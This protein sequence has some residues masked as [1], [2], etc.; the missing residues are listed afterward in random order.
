MVGF[1]VVFL[2]RNRRT[3]R[4][5]IPRELELVLEATPDTL[6][7]AV[8]F[9]GTRVLVQNLLDTL[10]E[11]GTVEEFLEG[12]PSVSRTQAEAVVRWQQEQTRVALGLRAGA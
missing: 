4:D 10:Q 8:R 12:F 9:R 1:G 6:S 11:G 3:I 7:G 5:M 2:A